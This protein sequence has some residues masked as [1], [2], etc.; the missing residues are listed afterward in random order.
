VTAALEALDR[1]LAWLQAT[2]DHGC[3]RL[4]Q[5]IYEWQHALLQMT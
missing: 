4:L 3:D 2:I 5:R 1:F